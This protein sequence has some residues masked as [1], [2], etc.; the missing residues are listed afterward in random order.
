M[1][2]IKT[3]MG[4]GYNLQF[5]IEKIFLL[6]KNRLKYGKLYYFNKLYWINPQKLCYV[7]KPCNR[8][9]CWHNYLRISDG[10]WDEP[11][12]L[13]NDT[14]QYTLIK[15]RIVE[16]KEWKDTEYY[17]YALKLINEKKIKKTIWSIN[18]KK[19]LDKILKDYEDLYY[20]IKNNG[21]K[22]RKELFSRWKRLDVRIALINEISVDIGRDGR[23]LV[24]HGKHRL[25]IAKLLNIPL[26]PIVIL[27]RHKEWIKL[28]KSFK[29]HSHPDIIIKRKNIFKKNIKRFI[30][31]LLT[32]LINI[33]DNHK[34]IGKPLLIIWN[35]IYRLK[36]II[37][38]NIFRS[39]NQLKNKTILYI[40]PN[41]IFLPK[42]LNLNNITNISNLSNDI[43][44][45]IN[46]NGHFILVNGI[47]KETNDKIPVIINNRHEKWIKFKEK[48]NYLSY[49]SHLYQKLTHPDL[50]DFQSSYGNIRFGFIKK[51]LSVSIG[52]LLDIGT[53][54]G[55]FCHKFE[56]LGFDCYGVEK[57]IKHIYFLK[58]LK[59]AENKKFKIIPKSIF[60]Y[61]K[62]RK[63]NFDVVLAL[64]IFHHF[65]KKKNTYLNLIKLLNRLDIKEMFFGA[66]N[67]KELQNINGYIN[68]NPEE[69]VNFIIENSCL[70]KYELIGIIKNHR[71]HIYKLTV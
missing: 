7:S 6:L 64:F 63:L 62:N 39:T 9:R 66:H 67:P 40:N 33:N 15:Q 25:A 35:I 61:K 30:R 5:I 59:K 31:R 3:I 11:D 50:Q 41:N 44:V 24:N 34:F 12:M 27:K 28:R 37:G 20:K 52:T 18:T 69:F 46:K 68:Y 1:D 29:D 2:L 56:D 32:I 43:I 21:Y 54:L 4:L 48:I 19:E 51:K 14:T 70:N 47:P 55:Y 13:F 53:Y 38:R 22:T 58:K 42:K 57:N 26:V 49:H 65:L 16:K 36:F 17:Q 60:S 45:D 10:D 23:F 71:R 8:N